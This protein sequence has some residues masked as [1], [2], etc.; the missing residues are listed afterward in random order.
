MPIFWKYDNKHIVLIFMTV[1]AFDFQPS[2]VPVVKILISLLTYDPKS[3]KVCNFGTRGLCKQCWVYL[4][5]FAVYLMAYS[6]A[7]TIYHRMVG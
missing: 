7:Q 4:I 3:R 6:V 1:A 5:L 2:S